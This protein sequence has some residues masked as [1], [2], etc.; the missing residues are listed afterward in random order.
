MLQCYVRTFHTITQCY[1]C[2]EGG[3]MSWEGQGRRQKFRAPMQSSH[4]PLTF[5]RKFACSITGAS[6]PIPDRCNLSPVKTR[7]KVQQCWD[8]EDREETALEDLE[9]KKG[10]LS[11]WAR[12][13]GRRGFEPV[14]LG[15]RRH[16]SIVW[17]AC[18]AIRGEKVGVFLI[19]I[20]GKHYFNSID[21]IIIDFIAVT[22]KRQNV[23][24][25]LFS[26]LVLVFFMISMIW[27]QK[28]LKPKI[29]YNK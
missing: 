11:Y 26:T 4:G 7:R 22:Q 8:L 13:G 12:E 25:R 20:F 27:N 2:I 19:L 10:A 29:P 18:G 17:S 5:M 15:G 1:V 9:G 3:V 23:K 24:W 16:C 21:W 6:I 28:I 14:C